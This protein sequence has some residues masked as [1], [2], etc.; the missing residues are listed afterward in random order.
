MRIAVLEWICG[1]GCE[2][3]EA[4][5]SE[6]SDLFDEG[7]QMLAAVTQLLSR[8]G[9]VVE[10][11]LDTK[12]AKLD[13]VERSLQ[14]RLTELGNV[15]VSHIDSQSVSQSLYKWGQIANRCDL[16]IAIAPE[17]DG[18]LER[19]VDTLETAG[20]A[21]LNCSGDFLEKASDKLLAAESLRTSDLMHP[22][23]TNLL[24][25]NEAWLEANSQGN[26]EEWI[27]KPRR[28]ADCHQI[29]ITKNP[30]LLQAEIG[31]PEQ[32]IVQPLI[33][34]Q[35]FSQSYFAEPIGKLHR[36]AAM[37][38]RIERMSR[39]DQSGLRF[40]EVVPCQ[41]VPPEL[42]PA[43][44]ERILGTGACGWIGFDWLRD[45]EDRWWLIEC[46]PR[47][48]TSVASLDDEAEKELIDC[49]ARLRA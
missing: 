46:N 36:F 11:A 29:V 49:I 37:R 15:A 41:E 42:T 48:T 22:P 9:H 21:L 20:C 7:W 43:E 3:A 27:I 39:L 8:A 10:L 45:A 38:Q 2:S 24:A 40:V 33:S 16:S 6:L 17:I 35:S 47:F 5:L 25:L 14:E 30:C 13:F 4:G 32:W 28:G 18:V 31:E 1:S 23:T 26:N 44:L 19:V 34:G 12:L